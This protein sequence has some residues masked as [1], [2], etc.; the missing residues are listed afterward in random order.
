[1]APKYKDPET[2][3]T[4]T[5]RGLKPKWLANALAAGRE[6]C[7]FAIKEPQAETEAA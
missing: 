4:W 7:E 6:I 2:G 1:M 5:G 3:A